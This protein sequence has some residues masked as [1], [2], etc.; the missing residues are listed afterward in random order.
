VR[1]KFRDADVVFPGQALEIEEEVATDNYSY[2]TGV[3]FKADRY[4]KGNAQN[5]QI[6]YFG[7]DN[8]GFCGDLPLAKGERYLVY[9][10]RKK[11]RLVTQIDCGPNRNA[12]Y[13]EDEIKK[14]DKFSFRIFA[15]LFPFPKF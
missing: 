5:A 11:G 2:P 15:W 12:K 10:Y 9:A 6:I 4:W 3:K 13:A 14:L 8:P 1:E 7:F